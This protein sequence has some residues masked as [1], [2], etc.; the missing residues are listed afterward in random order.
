MYTKKE[1][2]HF[3][4]DDFI[5]L[6]KLTDITFDHEIINRDP[7]TVKPLIRAYIS[8]DG[9]LTKKDVITR[10]FINMMVA[11]LIEE[12]KP[13]RIRIVPTHHFSDYDDE[14]YAKSIYRVEVEV[15]RSEYHRFSELNIK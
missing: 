10:T 12:V 11:G 14:G 5:K 2:F 15:Y 3:S 7:L 8:E 4:H 6:A 1:S 9:E 13:W